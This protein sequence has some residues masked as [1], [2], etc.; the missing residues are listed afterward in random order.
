MKKEYYQIYAEYI[1]KFLNAYTENGLK[2]WAISTGNE[3][4]NGFIP[5]DPLSAMGWTPKTVGNWVANNLGPTLAASK[6][7]TKI[8]ALDDQRIE[9]PWFVQEMF[10][11]KKAKDYISGVAVHWYSDFIAPPS[12]L[13][14]THNSFPDKF[15]LMTEAC[16]GE[17][18]CI[19][20]IF[21][22]L[23]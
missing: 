23:R 20:E 17:L 21:Y 13:D 3:P 10:K 15:I 22:S 18:E 7:D 5:F 14:L 12:L 4:L 6:H 9:L 2:I 19:Q 1:I 11:N 8:L 16:E